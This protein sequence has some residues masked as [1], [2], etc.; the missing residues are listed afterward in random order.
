[1]KRI[2]KY[3][4]DFINKDNISKASYGPD[5]LTRLD[6]RL[7]QNLIKKP[8]YE[9]VIEKYEKNIRLILLKI[10]KENY[11][12][13]L[14]E[15][16]INSKAKEVYEGVEDEENE[17]NKKNRN[18]KDHRSHDKKDKNL[19]KKLVK[20]GEKI[21]KEKKGELS[22]FE[23][24]LNNLNQKHFVISWKIDNEFHRLIVHSICRW[25]G[26]LSYSKDKED[27]RYTYIEINPYE[28]NIKE[29]LANTF[30]KYIYE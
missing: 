18:E 4:N 3:T 6:R 7:K 1:L 17:K 8:Q 2:S 9:K 14:E 22:I 13:Q 26:L 21:K 5:N 12:K 10:Q 16:R 20:L 30:V 24:I 23:T 25:Y 29:K 15:E 11:K 19:S 28:T 27:G